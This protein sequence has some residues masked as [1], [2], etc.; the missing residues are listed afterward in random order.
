LSACLPIKWL[1]AALPG[2]VG[3]ALHS[4][5]DHWTRDWGAPA[6]S[7]VEVRLLAAWEVPTTPPAAPWSDLSAAWVGALARALLGPAAT[8]SPVA[9]GAVQRVT[10]DLQDTLRQRFCTRP[11][12]PF[13]P[14]RVGHGGVQASFELLGQSFGFVLDVAELQSGSWLPAVARKQLPAIALERALHDVPVPLTA[15][16]GHASASVTDIL[17]LRPGDILLLDETLDAPLQV[18]S[19]GSPLQLTAHLGAATASSIP[20]RRAVRWLASS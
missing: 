13:V 14:A 19:P 17:Q 4:L 7:A 1:P 2:E 11:S 20:A 18:D 6:A 15:R 12:Q 9:L 3:A 16:L 5:L 10:A 8:A